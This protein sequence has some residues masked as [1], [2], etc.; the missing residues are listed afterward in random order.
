MSLPAGTLLLQALVQ[1][2]GHNT[3]TRF[4]LLWQPDGWLIHSARALEDAS[5]GRRCNLG[6]LP[7]PPR[8]LPEKESAVL[9]YAGQMISRGVE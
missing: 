2:P 7:K 5:R 4:C 6:H 8:R 9:R 3:G 1:G